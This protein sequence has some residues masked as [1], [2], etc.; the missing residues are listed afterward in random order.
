M[1]D[2][3]FLHNV[4]LAFQAPTAGVLGSLFAVPGDK[5]VVCNYLGADKSLFKISMNLARGFRCGIAN[6]DCLGSY[7]LN[8]GGEISLQL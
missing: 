3:A 7:F 6:T 5:V 4:F 1:Y 2:V 8:A